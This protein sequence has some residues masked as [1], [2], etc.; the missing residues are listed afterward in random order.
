MKN[1]ESITIAN[2][3]NLKSDEVKIVII[4][5]NNLHK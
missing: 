2:L 1:H 4:I 5:K 3:K